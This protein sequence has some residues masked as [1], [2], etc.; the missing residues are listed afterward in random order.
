MGGAAAAGIIV[1]WEHFITASGAV[2]QGMQKILGY[3]RYR[4]ETAFSVLTTVFNFERPKSRYVRVDYSYH[5]EDSSSYHQLLPSR[6]PN[7]RD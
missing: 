1:K 2:A 6:V 7:P 5:N 4:V 3:L